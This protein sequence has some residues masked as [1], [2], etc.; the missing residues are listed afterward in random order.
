MLRGDSSGGGGGLRGQTEAEIVIRLDAEAGTMEV[1]GVGFV[2]TE[3]DAWVLP[4]AEELGEVIEHHEK[5]E[6]REQ[7]QK[8]TSTVRPSLRG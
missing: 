6:R 2:G 1:E 4:I 7:V 3:C 5:P 8:Q